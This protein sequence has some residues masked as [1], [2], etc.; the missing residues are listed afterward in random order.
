MPEKLNELASRSYSDMRSLQ[1]SCLH[2]R[3]YG[4]ESR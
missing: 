1:A 4:A 2:R 3:W